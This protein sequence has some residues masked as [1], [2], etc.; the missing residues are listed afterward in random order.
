MKNELRPGAIENAVHG[1]QDGH[2]AGADR[3]IRRRTPGVRMHFCTE[4]PQPGAERGAYESP[5]TCNE[6]TPMLQVALQ[7]A[8]VVHWR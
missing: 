6:A 7:F 8:W 4:G 2:V 1:L 3:S 5:G